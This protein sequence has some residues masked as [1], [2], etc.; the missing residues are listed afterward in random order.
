MTSRLPNVFI[1]STFYDLRQVRANI[2]DFV[3]ELGY[4]FLASEHPSFP[5]DPSVTAIENCRRRVEADADI[6]VLV[7]GA[8][9]GSTLPDNS[10]SVTNVEYLTARAKG[11]PVY[12]FLTHDLVT[13]CRLM[14]ANPAIDLSQAVDSPKLFDFVREL[15]GADGVWTFEFSLAQDITSILRIQFAYL[16]ARGLDTAA[17]L[18]SAAP[19][20]H[21]LQG[22][23][24][25]LL[26]EKPNGW[27]PALF[28]EL[29]AEQLE[30]ASD[31]RQDHILGISAGAGERLGEEEV[32]RWA[33]SL[34]REA[35]RI[36]DAFVKLTTSSVHDALIAGDPQ[37][38]I[39][40]T[41]H[42]GRMYREAL[43]WA[44]RVRR[45]HVPERWQRALAELATML[46]EVIAECDAFV[47]RTRKQLHD[48]L[49]DPRKGSLLLELGFKFSIPDM[50]TLYVELGRLANEAELADR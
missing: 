22:E 25:R 32:A 31:A 6:L 3:R 42:I 46:D 47:P 37:A 7:V 28:I 8:R 9:Y 1:S 43:S 27:V 38:V 39:Y 45:V 2:A 17:K 49:N 50:T 18:R 35:T 44:A 48:A 12:A 20:F 24:L 41:R 13:Y 5:V 26:V 11:I 10:R 23:P 21:G 29:L 16:F 36:I 33:G 14:E 34:C 19:T 4:G 15:R 40:A 30:N